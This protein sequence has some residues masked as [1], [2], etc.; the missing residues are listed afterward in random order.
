MNTKQSRWALAVL[1]LL[2]GCVPS[3]NPVYTD[4]QL[5]FERSVLG[6]WLQSNN[7][8][9]FTKRDDQSYRLIYTEKDGK[10]GQFIAHL[11]KVDGKLFLDLIPEEA[12]STT[13][14][15]YKFHL[16]PLHT[17]YLVK[18]TSELKMELA[19]FDYEWLDHYLTNHPS[20]IEFATFND[21]KVLTAPTNDVQEFVL[22][23][24]EMFTG[25]FHLE[26]STAPVN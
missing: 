7:R 20:R 17:I 18:R 9:E 24:K 19:A 6:I 10:Q 15:F 1:A 4:D 16:V 2:V 23:H 22:E 8:W 12:N 5:V 3:L 21:R 14:G 13:S 26:R 25:D 11:A